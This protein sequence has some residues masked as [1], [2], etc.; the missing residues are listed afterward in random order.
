MTPVE[1]LSR[2]AQTPAERLVAQAASVPP[3]PIDRAGW[4]EV[5]SLAA[6]RPRR[7]WRLVPAFIA[8]VGV[9]AA[10]VLVLQPSPAP[11]PVQFV[12]SPGAKWSQQRPDEVQLTQGQLRLAHA[13][14]R[15]VRVVTPHVQVEARRSRFLAEVITAGTSIVVE[16]GEVIVRA[17]GETRTLRK[18]E[19]LV[20]PPAPTIPAGLLESEAP[21]AS[22]CEQAGPERHD[23]LEREALGATLDAQAALYEL[24]VLEAA[25]GRPDAAIAAWQRS[26]DRFPDGVLHP[27]VRLRLLVELVRARRFADAARVAA[28]FER[29]C[30]ADPRLDDVR[31]LE[32]R[33]PRE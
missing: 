11:S 27:E 6:L 16:E 3:R 22:T 15:L 18:G 2:S 13:S 25:R 12:A 4:D 19:S 32:A 30:T 33:L 29:R 7:D 28:E 10:L 24:G 1:P 20:W 9:G 5:A 31:L 14:P 23:C 26:L 21:A 8:A 17:G